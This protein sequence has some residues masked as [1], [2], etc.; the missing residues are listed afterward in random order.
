MSEQ[1]PMWER[2]SVAEEWHYRTPLFMLTIIASRRTHSRKTWPD[3]TWLV[4][5]FPD[6]VLRGDNDHPLPTRTPERDSR[7]PVHEEDAEI[8]KAEALTLLLE[9]IAGQTELL[10][11]W[12]AVVP[13]LR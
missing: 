3:G 2:G 4:R 11:K 10:A 12:A 7:G 8:A 6:L 9:C 5:C 1:E 13:S